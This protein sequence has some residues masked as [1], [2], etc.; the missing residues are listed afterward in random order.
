MGKHFMTQQLIEEI[1]IELASMSMIIDDVDFLL[2]EVANN[3]PNNIHKTA[4]AGFAAQFYNGIENI[5]KRIHKYYKL[6]LPNGQD[7]HIVILERFSQDS[8][9][10]IPIKLSRDLI[11]KLAN[12]RRFRHYFF[13]GYSHNL[14]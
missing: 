7:W 14:N 13:H 5:F 6:E 8:D 1:K 2:K 12:Y 4:L 3:P 11:E 10:D 9:F